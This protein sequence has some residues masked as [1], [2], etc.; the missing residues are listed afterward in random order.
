MF[1][2]WQFVVC[3]ELFFFMFP[4]VEM[5]ART[6]TRGAVSTTEV[7]HGEGLGPESHL[8]QLWDVLFGMFESKSR[9]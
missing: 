9:I 3:I 2:T 8:V 1:P 5:D 7:L 4:R 6:R